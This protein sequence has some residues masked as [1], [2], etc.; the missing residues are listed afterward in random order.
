M[1][2]GPV[3]LSVAVRGERR[4]FHYGILHVVTSRLRCFA[5]YLL[6]CGLDLFASAEHIRADKDKNEEWD[7]S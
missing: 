1:L 3:D 2:G 6:P 4:V 7:E 5:F